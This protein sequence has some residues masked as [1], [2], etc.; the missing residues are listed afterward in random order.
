MISALPGTTSAVICS[1]CPTGGHFRKT[2]RL[3]LPQLKLMDDIGF[4]WNIR[5]EPASLFLALAARRLGRICQTK[6]WCS[7]RTGRIHSCCEA[8]ALR[9]RSMLRALNAQTSEARALHDAGEV[10][11]AGTLEVGDGFKLYFEEHGVLDGLPAVFLHGGPGAGCSRRMAQLFDLSKYRVVLLDQ[12]GCGK[13]KRPG[14]HTAQLHC[15]TTWHLVE[16]LE[17]LRDHLQIDKWVVAG[18]SWGTCL[19]LAYASRHADRVLAMVLRAVCLFREEEL[20]FF[21]GPG[22]GARTVDRDAWRNLTDWLP[23][24]TNRT[25]PRIIAAA[26]RRAVV[27]EDSAM[28]PRDA[29]GKWWQWEAKLI[30][31]RDPPA[32]SRQPLASCSDVELPPADP[33]TGPWQDMLMWLA[34]FFMG[35]MAVQALLTMHY[36]AE[37]AF[38]LPGFELLDAARLFSFPIDVVHGRNDCI[39]PVENAKDL[40]AVAPSA[41]LHVTD[42]GHSQWDANNVD[43]F[44]R[45]TDHIAT[46]T[47]IRSL[48]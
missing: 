34:S 26:F 4:G 41:T 18:G 31:A 29:M 48:A 11:R 23:W 44:V 37:R 35:N 25:S 6:P 12:R 14:D 24:I 15:N 43:A 7:R 2:S 22:P 27:G 16:D 3:D 45:A 39:C 38:F 46:C 8:S 21:L 47:D 30:T 9:S 28:S 13:S 1:A 19:A 17:A 20:G 5:A 32:L 40:V 36:V 10:L 42:A 33:P